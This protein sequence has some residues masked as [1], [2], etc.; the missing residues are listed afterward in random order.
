MGLGVV[1]LVW[2]WDHLGLLRGVYV[3]CNIANMQRA[4]LCCL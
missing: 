4:G 1:P 3:G 2:V